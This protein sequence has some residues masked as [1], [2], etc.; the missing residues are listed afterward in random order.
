[1]KHRNVRTNSKKMWKSGGLRL[2]LRSR[3]MA[4]ASKT[5]PAQCLR[6]AARLLTSTRQ[7]RSALMRCVIKECKRQKKLMKPQYFS[8]SKTNNLKYLTMKSLTHAVKC[9]RSWGQKTWSS[10]PTSW[11]TPKPPTSNVYR[12]RSS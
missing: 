11:P 7:N 1:M 3:R 10:W 2:L 5:C 12:L 6:K 4:S 8:G 9:N